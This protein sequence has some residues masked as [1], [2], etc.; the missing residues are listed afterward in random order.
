MFDINLKYLI[1]EAYKL[2]LH[3]KQNSNTKSFTLCISTKFTLPEEVSKKWVIDNKNKFKKR[4]YPIIDQISYG[5]HP[6]YEPKPC[7]IDFDKKEI[8]CLNYKAE[9]IKIQFSKYNASKLG[10]NSDFLC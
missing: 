5:L 8:T 9:K 6:I 7:E 4:F 1:F 3:I 2:T 10:I